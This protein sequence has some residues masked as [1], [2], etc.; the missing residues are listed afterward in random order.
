MTVQVA[1]RIGYFDIRAVCFVCRE[2]EIQEKWRSRARNRWITAQPHLLVLFAD[3]FRTPYSL[4]LVR[5]SDPT[6]SSSRNDERSPQ[7]AESAIRQL[8]PSA[9]D[10]GQISPGAFFHPG[11]DGSTEAEIKGTAENGDECIG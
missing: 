1:G 10:P 7:K 2:F 5:S 8:S 3:H 11:S 4:S 9:R 6:H